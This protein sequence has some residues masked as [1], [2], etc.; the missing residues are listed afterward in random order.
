MAKI[1]SCDG[2]KFL[3]QTQDG[4]VDCDPPMGECPQEQY[5]EEWRPDPHYKEQYAYACGYYD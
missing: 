4:S 2:C 1:H 3:L 5:I